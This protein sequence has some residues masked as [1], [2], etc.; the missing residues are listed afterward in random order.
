MLMEDVSN[1]SFNDLSKDMFRKLGMSSST[2][3][4]PLPENLHHLVVPGHFQNGS[5]VSMKWNN[6]PE[7]S[8][9]SLWTTAIDLLKWSLD[10][11]KTY[12][13]ISSNYLSKKTVEEMLKPVRNF[14][15]VNLFFYFK[16]GSYGSWR[17]S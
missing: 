17:R 12:N 9:A 7:Q 4:S 5:E 6:Y 13:G 16:L 14:G 3:E 2:Y 10:I 15:L 8:A 1:Q 11:S